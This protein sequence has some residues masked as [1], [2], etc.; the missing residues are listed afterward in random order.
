MR[1]RLCFMNLVLVLLVSG[2]AARPVNPSFA[3]SNDQ[4]RE[5]LRAMAAQPKPLNRPLVI[6]NGYDDPGMG[7][8]LVRWQLDPVI[9]DRRGGAGGVQW[10]AAVEES[11]DKNVAGGGE[12]EGGGGGK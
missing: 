12:W 3:I 7:S 10:G 6:V 1:A 11:G 5:A 8:L 4:A 9:R 2:C